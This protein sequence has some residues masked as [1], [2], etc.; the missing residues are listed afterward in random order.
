M[1]GIFWEKFFVRTF[2]GRTFLGGTFW[3]NFLRGILCLHWL[4]YLNMIGIDLFVKILFF[5]KILSQCRTRKEGNFQSLEVRG[6]VPSHLK[7]H[8]MLTNEF[9]RQFTVCSFAI[10]SFAIFFLSKMIYTCL[11]WYI[12]IS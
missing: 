6:Q 7:I 4:S 10:H 12:F 9:S 3:E 8:F 5:V 2:S 1:G 11:S